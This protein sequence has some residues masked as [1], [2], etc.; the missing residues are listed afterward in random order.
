MSLC[1][2]LVK[3]DRNVWE[4]RAGEVPDGHERDCDGAHGEAVGLY[5][6]V[7]KGECGRCG[8][9]GRLFAR[10]EGDSQRDVC[11]QCVCDFVIS[12][13]LRKMV[14]ARRPM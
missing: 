8:D 14:T 7:G 11:R 12:Q 6:Y 10:V 3:V 2:G 5:G 1:V 9:R 13:W 4:A